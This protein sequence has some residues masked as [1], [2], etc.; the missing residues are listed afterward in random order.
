M[1]GLDRS[2][3]NGQDGETHQ[4]IY[5]FAYL[6]HLPN[7]TIAAPF[8]IKEMED[9]LEL[10]MQVFDKEKNPEVHGC[11]VIR[12]P[13]KERL[14]ERK[15]L[16]EYSPVEY[17]KGAVIFDTTDGGEAELCIMTAGAIVEE[18]LK[19]A[20]KLAENGV[21]V[22]VFN[23]RFIKPLD[24]E[25]VLKNA[26]GA[27]CVITAEEAVEFGGF[28]ERVKLICQNNNITSKIKVIALPDAALPHG[29]ISQIQKLYGL[30]ADGIIKAYEDLKN[31]T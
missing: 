17:G 2:G 13:A 12:Y 15:G 18:A 24:E 29:K 1:I 7:T 3:I 31:E 28:G 25:G 19:A 16:L 26:T 14:T 21:K 9:M 23:A 8:S 11:F 4:G 6:G 20:E 22:R 5:D 10:G 30:D 27:K